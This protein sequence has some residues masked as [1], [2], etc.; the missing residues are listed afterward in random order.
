[1][2]LLLTG[3]NG[4]I[5]SFFQK[6]YGERYDIQT[7]S[8]LHDHFDVLDLYGVDV[9]VHLSALVHQPKATQAMFFEANVKHTLSLAQKAKE[10]GAKHFIFMSTIAVYDQSIVCLREDSLL[11]PSS[12]YGSSKLEAEQQLLMLEDEH[13]KISIVR[14]PMVYGYNAPGNIKSLM[15]LID[16][17]PLLPFGNINN[18][19]SFIYVGNLCA[20]IDCIIQTQKRGIFLASDDIP[21]STTKLIELIANA[22]KQKVYLLNVK[23]L[24]GLL[25]WLKPSLYQRLFESLEI[26]NTKTKHFLNFKNPYN[27]H[28]GIEKMVRG[29]SL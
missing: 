11:G 22:K 27:V 29:E 3:A 28:E 5:G 21:L 23:F 25:K 17:I 15:N 20:M 8:F 13:F 19:R 16:K 12:L 18:K 14:P 4:F 9:I 2:R 1:M 10:S 6:M 24:E 26:D 7:F